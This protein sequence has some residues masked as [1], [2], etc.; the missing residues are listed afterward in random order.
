[1][2]IKSKRLYSLLT[3]IVID[4]DLAVFTELP[5][6]EFIPELSEHFSKTIPK[7]IFDFSEGRHKPLLDRLS[8]LSNHLHLKFEERDKYP[9]TI[10]RICELSYHPLQYFP[11]HNLEKFVTAMEKCC[12][13]DTD[14]SFKVGND[15]SNTDPMED[16]SLIPI[17]WLDSE[18]TY[19]KSLPSLL[20]RIDSIV[21]V[22]FGYEDFDD[23]NEDDR[24]DNMGGGYGDHDDMLREE[25]DG[26]DEESE[27]EDYEEEDDDDEE[28]GSSTD[29]ITVEEGDGE[30]EDEEERTSSD[31]SDDDEASYEVRNDVA[32][33]LSKSAFVQ[34]PIK[35]AVGL[36]STG[37]TLSLDAASTLEDDNESVLSRKRNVTELDDYQY[38][39][40]KQDDGFI[41]TPKKSKMHLSEFESSMVSPVVSN[42]ENSN[43]TD[44][45]ITNA[46][47]SPDTN[48]S[49]TQAEKKEL[50]TSP[51]QDKKRQ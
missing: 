27:D 22:N 11:I 44:K 7:E 6:S 3:R 34:I 15:F 37:D 25:Y 35:E 23:D 17:D 49:V 24:D 18:E 30:G 38:K 31:I 2:G 48:N 14:W 12:L 21:A 19:D 29:E 8:E 5:S 4:K 50:S 42:G 20:A 28:I 9:F 32:N 33:N 36:P 40:V 43:K 16:V 46:L 41:T 26:M 10:Q 47:V 13:V 51:L 39:E 1:M 45:R